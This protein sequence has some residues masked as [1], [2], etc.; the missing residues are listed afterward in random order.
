MTETQIK[1]MPTAEMEQIMATNFAGFKFTPRELTPA[2]NMWKAEFGIVFKED[3]MNAIRYIRKHYTDFPQPK[4]MWA[5]LGTL[6]RK[7]SMTPDDS[8]YVALTMPERLDTAKAKD[9]FFKWW[10][11]LYSKPV[12]L[13]LDDP[14]T[15]GAVLYKY[16]KGCYDDHA[17]LDIKQDGDFMRHLDELLHR[18]KQYSEHK[19]LSQTI[20]GAG[21]VAI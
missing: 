14:E 7:E 18:M 8:E 10:D 19:D 13:M 4:F 9:I 3:F 1:T 17:G 21:E 5:V 2:A 11:W 12:L 20:T 15:K 6:K 16:Y